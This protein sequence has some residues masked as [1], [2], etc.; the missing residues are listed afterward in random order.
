MLAGFVIFFFH[1]TPAFSETLLPTSF[2]LSQ[3]EEI[4]KFVKVALLIDVPTVHVSTEGP[5]QIGGRD[6]SV[7]KQSEEPL[8]AQVQLQS[9][10]IG[11][12]DQVLPEKSLTLK[13]IRGSIQVEKRKYYGE[14][15]ILKTSEQTIT[16]INRI[17]IEEYLKGVLPLEVHPNWPIESLKAHAV[18]SRTLALFKAIEKKDQDFA[19][20]DTIYSQVYGGALFH[21]PSTDLAVEATQSEILTFR[22]SIFPS[23]FHAACGGITEK[24]DRIWPLQ[25]NEVFKSVRCLFC[26]G[27]KHWK[28][29]LEIP[30]AEV[31][32]IMQKR[33]FPAKDL[34]NIVFLNRTTTGRISKVKLEYQRSAVAISASDFRA[35]LGYDRLRS[36]KASV[37]V[38]GKI[39]YFSGYGWGHGIG[40]CQWGAKGQAEAGRNY[41]EILE[42]YF[43]E[44]EVKKV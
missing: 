31:E 1:V 38:K 28:W 5:Y 26:K 13:P 34:K 9:G 37:K 32:A 41:R 14:I 27:T 43:P 19:L 11:I 18:A 8:Q 22:G 33:G 12:N 4:P 24:A 44:S 10:G 2:P 30:L 7:L 6:G 21:K 15:Q 3:A 35:F 36:L 20:R 23:Y 42:F 17:D 39:A 25:P 16:V 29:N 40:F